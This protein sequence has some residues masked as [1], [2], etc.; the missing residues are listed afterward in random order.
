MIFFLR[1]FGMLIRALIWKIEKGGGRLEYAYYEI[2]SFTATAGMGNPAGVVFQD[3]SLTD[4]DM[5]AIAGQIG[6]EMAFLHPEEDTYRIQF[7]TA[8]ARIPL[9]GHDTIATGVVMAERGELAPGDVMVFKSD[10]GALKIEYQDGFIWMTQLTPEFGAIGE[11]GDIA[12]LLGV[13]PDAVL[14]EPPPRIV[15]TGTQFLLA[16]LAGEDVIQ[17]LTPDLG[18][19]TDYLRGLDSGAVGVYVWAHRAEE[20]SVFHGRCFAPIAGLPEDPVTGSA[21]GALISYFVSSE[22]GMAGRFEAEV[23]QG[24][25]SGRNGCAFV[26]VDLDD[27][28]VG[29]PRVGGRGVITKSGTGV[30][31]PNGA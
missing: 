27:G 8:E 23:R 5:R 25:R 2:D 17:S 10:I 28:R 4:G 12:A 18:R 29:R 31:V 21:S 14:S 13:A 19:M 9:C 6:R 11:T 3:G 7:Y 26:D 22:P 20:R 15:S 30:W 1:V 16:R 24:P